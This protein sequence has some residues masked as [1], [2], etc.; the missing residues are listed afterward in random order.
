MFVAAGPTMHV[1]R[2]AGIAGKRL[3]RRDLALG[4]R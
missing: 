1:S 3:I 2:W 4:D